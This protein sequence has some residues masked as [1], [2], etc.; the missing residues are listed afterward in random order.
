MENMNQKD[1]KLWRI[2]KRRAE[3]KRH[4]FTYLLVNL[5]LWGIWLFAGLKNGH[6][7]FIWPFFVTVGWGIG[8]TS[9][10][11]AV[12][13]NIKESLADREYHK[14]IDKQKV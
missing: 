11:L 10:Y 8:L 2:A 13:T 5:F 9:N 3:F 12:Y 1:E 7:G 14:L 4:L 6:F